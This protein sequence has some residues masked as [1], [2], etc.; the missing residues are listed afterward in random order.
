MGV[1][2]SFTAVATSVATVA[3]VTVL[4]VVT[5][6]QAGAAQYQVVQTVNV[7]TA[8]FGIAMNQSSSKA[9][10]SHYLP[11]TDISVLNTATNQED[12]PIT[13]V[14]DVFG[15]ALNV[16]DTMYATQNWTGS[17]PGTRVY[18]V[19]PGGTSPSGAITVLPR[20]AGVAVNSNVAGD[21]NDDT[22]YAAI[23]D[24][25]H[26]SVISGATNTEA[27]TVN[28]GGAPLNVA[29]DSTDENDIK[30]NEVFWPRV[31]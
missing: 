3:A 14:T 7:G 10:I 15:I 1:R 16:D 19:A 23:P 6:A 31:R 21:P 22:I 25:S 2:R 30:S 24:Q 26:I 28:V 13:G 5:A 27:T 18:V 17:A 8:A 4:G 12:S 11:G 29:V 20:P 9:Y